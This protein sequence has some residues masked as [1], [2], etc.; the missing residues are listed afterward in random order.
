M[1]EL[2]IADEPRFA[3]SDCDMVRIGATYTFDTVS[4]FRQAYPQAQ[5]WWL[6]G[7]DS[8]LHIHQWQRYQA[9][10]QQANF[11]VAPRGEGRLAAVA[12]AVQQWLPEA[13]AKAVRQPQGHDGGRLHLLQTPYWPISSTEIRAQ[14]GHGRAG[15][16]EVLPAAVAAYIAKNHLYQ[17]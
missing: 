8:L 5:L 14:C 6:M 16:Q 9:L 11:A 7:M 12:P 17:A 10:L 2:A 4:I 13:L 15:V 1:V 3:A